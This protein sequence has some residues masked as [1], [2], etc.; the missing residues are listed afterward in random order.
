MNQHPQRGHVI[1]VEGIDVLLHDRL[2]THR[3]IP[4]SAVPG[5]ALPAVAP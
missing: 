4:Q 2:V 1:T 3:R 5:A